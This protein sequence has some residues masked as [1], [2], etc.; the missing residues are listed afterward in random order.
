MASARCGGGGGVL[1]ALVLA[2]L[3]AL[4]GCG[5]GSDSQGSPTFA[6]PGSV[7]PANPEDWVCE[8]EPATQQEI[9]EWCQSHT[10]RGMPLPDELRH[11]PQPADFDA[12]G[13]YNA[14]LKEFL[15]KQEYL[16]LGWIHDKNWRLSGPAAV[17]PANF[18]G[19]YGPHFPLRVYYSPEVV[20]WLCNGRQGELP[21]GAAMIKAMDA[22]FDLL[23]V[24]VAADGCMDIRNDGPPL[25][26]IPLL[27]APMIKTNES[28]YDG[29]YWALPAVDLP[30]EKPN[31]PQFPPPL[32]DA[33]AFT[34]EIAPPLADNPSW[35]PTGGVLQDAAKPANVVELIPL[36]GHPYCLSCHATAV[37]QSTF[38]SM[39]N[40][41]G[42]ELRYKKF[43]RTPVTAATPTAA[44]LQPFPTPRAEPAHTFLDLYDQLE[45]VSFVQ[46]WATRMPAETYDKQ[47]I[48][49]HDG[50]GQFLTAAQCN[51][52]HNATPQSPLLPNMALVEEPDAAYSPLRNLSPYGEWR[53]SPM[54]LSGRDPIFFAQLQSE[55]NTLPQNTKCIETLCLHCHGAMGERQLAIDTPDQADPACQQM[56]AIPPPPEVPVGKPLARQALAAVAGQRR[57]RR[58]VLRRAGARRHLLHCLPSRRADGSRRGA[59]I[60]RQL[61]H[62]SGRQGLRPVQERLDRH[63]ADGAGAR[64][65]AAVRGADHQLRAVRQLPQH[66][67]ADLRQRRATARRELRAIDASGMAQQRQ[68]PGG[69]GFPLVSGLPHA[70]AVQRHRSRAQDRQQRDER[71]ISLP[72]PIGCPTTRSSSPSARTTRATRC[73][74]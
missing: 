28:S 72:R 50:P 35:Y 58:A 4:V 71:A 43:D 15:V 37:S 68:R 51:A 13:R 62:R 34:S 60:Y 42:K 32:F 27:W 7:L 41:L 46:A 40:I 20:D 18:S 56:F 14:R 54:G 57:A 23:G 2:P 24:D 21:D 52:C 39:D 61:H 53:V 64:H 17:P 10:E 30:P 3:L 70:D 65:H 1:L 67:A 6:Q 66:P 31:P 5:D 49:A 11:P 19:N 69:Q 47:V 26:P 25:P 36:A 38:A 45:P 8:G 73:T 33:S 48:S 12:Y 74:A 59:D 22:F 16:G 63:Q 9:D 29:W 55:T 44:A